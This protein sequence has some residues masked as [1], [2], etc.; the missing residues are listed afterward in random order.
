[1]ALQPRRSAANID[2]YIAGYPAPVQALLQSVRQTIARAVPDAQQKISYGIPTF[3]RHGNL[4]HFAAFDRH[5]GLYPGSAAIVAFRAELQAYRCSKGTV[6]LPL[7]QPLPLALI[8]RIV[9]YRIEH[10][11]A[12]AKG[13]K[14]R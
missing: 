7:D 3:A 9:A 10:D 14:T 2:E 11:A 1:M 5:I 4:V 8:A 13:R 6:R 12:R